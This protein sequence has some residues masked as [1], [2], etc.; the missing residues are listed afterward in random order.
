MLI[1]LLGTMMVLLFFLLILL[2]AKLSGETPVAS[3][4]VKR[5]GA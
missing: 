5:A 3:A 2:E 1:P 4:G